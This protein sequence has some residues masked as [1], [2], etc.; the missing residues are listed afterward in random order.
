MEVRWHGHACFEIKS[1]ITVIID[2][3]DGRSI[4][5]KAPKAKADVV[6]VTHHHFDH[7]ATRVIKGNFQVIDSPG[8]YQVQE[9]RIKGITAYHDKELGAR[10]GKITMFKLEAEGIRLLH[11][12]DLGHVLSKETVEEIGDIDILF[13]P[14]GGV[15]T[16]NATEAYEN[17][18]LLMPKIVVPMHY[19]FDG[20]TLGIVP[21][22]DFLR[23]FKEEDVTYVGNSI[24][25]SREDLPKNTRVWVFTL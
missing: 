9:F 11:V 15:Y 6:L 17:V 14:V 16:V 21:V 25:F 10:R 5:I 18:R 3:H 2:P 13:T 1:G 20:L 12:G 4:G 23:Y 7:D 19:K 24:E 8:E 22:D